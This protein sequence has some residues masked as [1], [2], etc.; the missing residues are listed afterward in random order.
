MSEEIITIDEFKKQVADLS[1]TV[2]NIKEPNYDAMLADI[3]ESMHTQIAELTKPVK[4]KSVQGENFGVYTGKYKGMNAN[5]LELHG[6]ICKAFNIPLSDEFTKAMDSTTA[7]SGNEWVPTLMDSV[8]WENWRVNSRIASLVRFVDMPSNP[9]TLPIK[10]SGM[11][12]YYNASENAATTASNPNTGSVTLTAGKIMGE[13]DFSDEINE[14]SILAIQDVLRAD[15]NDK[16]T[17]AIDNV[18][19]NGDATTGVL[20]INYYLAGGSNISATNKVLVFDG[21]RHF[22]L[23]DNTSQKSNLG[24][25]VSQDNFL[26]VLKLLGKYATRPTDL[27]CIADP[28]LYLSMLDISE[29]VTVDK[30]GPGATILNGEIGKFHGVPVIPSEELGKTDT[31]GYINQTGGSNTKGSFVIF[32]K[33]SFIAG[34]KRAVT[35]E[36]DRDI[37]KQ[38]TILVISTRMAFKPWGTASSDTYV[39]VGYNATI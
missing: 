17:E 3:K 22:G 37:Q 25:A 15:M 34:R 10:D 5:E 20:N 2:K 38:Q 21:L 27:A 28:W 35:I 9:Y 39:G 4:D 13:I 36:S 18:I 19:L 30:Y 32:H 16:M 7:D 6:R 12:I 8:L 29:I 1:D 33:P 26:T 31:A 14:D 11:T 24:A 23:V